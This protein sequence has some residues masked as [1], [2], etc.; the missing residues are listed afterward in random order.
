MEFLKIR[1]H[2]TRAMMQKLKRS[3]SLL[4]DCPKCGHGKSLRAFAKGTMK[5]TQC[6]G[7]YKVPA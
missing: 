7:I 2:I 5:C 6:E 4:Y 1:R 3:P